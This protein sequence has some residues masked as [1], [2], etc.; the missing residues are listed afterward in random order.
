MGGVTS[1]IVVLTVT[2]PT[3]VSI[4]ITPS[5]NPSVV[6]GLTIP[7]TAIGTYNNGT[8][9][10]LTSEVTWNSSNIGVA[11]ISNAAGSNGT[12]TGQGVGT[13]NITASLNGVTSNTVTLNGTAA[14]LVSISI[15]PSSNPSVVKGLTVPFTATGTYTDGT[16]VDLTSIVTWTS[17]NTSVATIS[18]AAGSNGVATGQ[19]VGTTNIV[20]TFNGTNS[21][22]VVLNGT[23]ATL[24]SIAV[25]PNASP[26]VVVG[27][28]IPFTATGT[29]TDGTTANLTSSVT[30]TSSNTS[31]ATISNATDTKGQATGA[32]AGSSNITA[33]LG[34]VTSPAIN[35][36]VNAVSLSSI[37]I[38]PIAPS[39][40]IV[41]G[42][43]QAFVAM[44]TYNNGQVL[45]ITSSVTW[46]T[47]NPTKISISNV[48][49]DTKGKATG[50][51][52]GS[53]NISASL[54]G[55][56]SN[57]VLLNCEAATLLS[58]VITPNS[59]PSVV[60]G[61]TLPFTAMGTYN[62]GQTVNITSSVTWSSSDTTKATIDNTATINRGVVT[63]IAVGSS[64]IS[65]SLNGVVSNVVGLTVNAPTLLSIQIDPPVKSVAKGLTQQFTATG[66]YG[67]FN[68]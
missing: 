56:T 42:S 10:D 12:A 21:N 35:L 27:L 32:G 11:T 18:N 64:N 40:V 57:V 34:G 7:F 46:N 5:S 52:P 9:V 20:A 38:T 16:T 67:E 39:N 48:A 41:G 29:Y 66:T 17:S 49:D 8:T 59:S 33:S 31:A 68:K 51:A 1:P 30:W 23:A 4:A 58:I 54:N 36:T 53:T 22:T 65:A 26:S 62:N 63:G 45:D 44:G 61:L 60:A 55:K 14:T 15:T 50:V 25:T 43:P 37:S 13:T 19:G 28:T 47:S 3:L 6:K 2:N 24:V